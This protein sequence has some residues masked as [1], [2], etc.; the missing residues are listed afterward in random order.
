M[1]KIF[2][3]TVLGAACLAPSLQGYYPERTYYSEE[4]TYYYPERSYS[5]SYYPRVHES[6]TWGDLFYTAAV[7]AGVA[8]LTYCAIK[9]EPFDALDAAKAS[10]N[11]LDQKLIRLFELYSDDSDDVAELAAS[12]YTRSAY[13]LVTVSKRLEAAQEDTK[14]ALKKVR[15]ALSLLDEDAFVRDC[16]RLQ[17]KLQ[18]RLDLINELFASIHTHPLWTGQY[19]LS[20]QETRM[21]NLERRVDDFGWQQRRV[22]VVNRW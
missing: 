5:R 11:A 3:S 15:K 16:S 9:Q 19:S 1:K 7:V 20:L 18:N 22:V 10:Y 17:R 21:R 6:S 8:G 4:I 14:F 12:L 13:P 2:L